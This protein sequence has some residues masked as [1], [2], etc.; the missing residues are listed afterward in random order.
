VN[1]SFP[2]G[3]V[4]EVATEGTLSPVELRFE[5]VGGAMPRG[6]AGTAAV[7]PR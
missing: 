1:R 7:V 6:P 3:V 2:I 5:T 4:L